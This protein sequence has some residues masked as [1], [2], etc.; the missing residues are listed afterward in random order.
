LALKKGAG[1]AMMGWRCGAS[2]DGWQV[3][4]VRGMVCVRSRRLNRV[5]EGEQGW[6]VRKGRDKPL[7]L[8]YQGEGC[9]QEGWG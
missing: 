3:I 1:A 9:G 4:V 2:S 7:P 6:Q 5:G 8:L